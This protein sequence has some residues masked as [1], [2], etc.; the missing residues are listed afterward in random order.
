M[1]ANDYGKIPGLDVIF[2]LGGYF[3]H[4]SYDTVERLLYAL[5]LLFLYIKV[6]WKFTGVSVM[7]TC[8]DTCANCQPDPAASKH[9][10]T[11][12]SV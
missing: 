7:F 10:G 9:V 11:I 4:T 1:F 3:Y 12:F 8:S 2:I 5:Q 6:T